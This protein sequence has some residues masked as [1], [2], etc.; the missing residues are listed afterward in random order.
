[1]SVVLKEHVFRCED[2]ARYLLYQITLGHETPFF[3][4]AGTCVRNDSESASAS[5][6]ASLVFFKRRSSSCR[7][8]R[9]EILA[10]Y[11]NMSKRK[12][13]LSPLEGF[14][15]K[16]SSKRIS[17][18]FF[19]SLGTD[20]WTGAAAL[21]IISDYAQSGVWSYCHKYCLSECVPTGYEVAGCDAKES[22]SLSESLREVMSQSHHLL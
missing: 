2:D 6:S 19:L 5:L 13:A 4:G 20:V 21:D 14:F 17:F 9:A 15:F 10:N 11:A 18:C 7:V 12:G 3:V 8:I 22:F 1:M 16:D